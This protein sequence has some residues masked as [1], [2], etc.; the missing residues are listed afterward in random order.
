MAARKRPSEGLQSQRVFQL[1]E[2]DI[3]TRVRPPGAR[4]V[5]DAIAV[6]LG[7]SRTPVR[8]AFRMLHRAGWLDLQPH[9]GAYVRVPSIEEARDVFDT[10]EALEREAA[11]YAAERA[12]EADL[13]ELGKIVE[14][15]RRARDRNDLK[16]LIALNSDFHRGIARAAGNRIL[17]RFLDDLDKRVR[18]HFAAIAGR[19]AGTSWDEHEE[20][21][22]AISAHEGERAGALSAEHSGRTRMAYFEHVMGFQPM[23][24]SA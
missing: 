6:E 15:G 13:Q 7:V 1:L 23:G 8:E 5:E 9:A 21:L 10:R 2:E 17:S 3:L 12:T 18:W 24:P 14:R 16:A 4:L 11:R 20:I 22:N 19:R